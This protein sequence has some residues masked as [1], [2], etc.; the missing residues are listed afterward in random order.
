MNSMRQ[1]APLAACSM[2]GGTEFGRGPNDRLS[3]SGVPPRCLECRSLERHRIIRSVY[4]ALPRPLLA[5][6]QALQFSDDIATPR[7]L[8]AAVEIS[9]HGGE[10]HL[11]MMEITR[12]DQSYDWVIANHVIEHVRDDRKAMAELLRIVKDDGVVQ[13]TFPTPST[14]LETWELEEP[15][16]DSY[17]HYRGYGSDFPLRMA[18]VLGA[19]LG[20]VVVGRDAATGCWDL[21]Y[22]FSRAKPVLFGLAKALLKAGFV[23]LRCA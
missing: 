8:F 17:D 22:F 4:D 1:I 16:P 13:L 5:S 6:R 9:V 18:P 21:V 23:V 2:C 3:A 15:D 7:Q 20:V 12:E 14:A 19:A 11:D 10:N